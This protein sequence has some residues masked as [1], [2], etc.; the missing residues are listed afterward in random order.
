MPNKELLRRIDE[1]DY[2]TER[3]HREFLDRLNKDLEDYEELKK[4]MGTPIQ[5]IMKRLKILDILKN[6]SYIIWVE[7]DILYSGRCDDIE[8]PLD[9]EDFESE[10]DYKL[11]KEYF[12]KEENKN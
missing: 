11:I 3:E 12:K 2:L 9:K 6:R 1:R 5:D 10:E 4:I 7:K 8:I